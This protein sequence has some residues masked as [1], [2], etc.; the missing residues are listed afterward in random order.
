MKKFTQRWASFHAAESRAFTLIELLVVIT[1]IAI[2]AAM[3]LPALA[4]AKC[5]ATK[6][7]CIS[8]KHQIQLA[9]AMYSHDF[10]DWLVPNSPAGFAG[11][12][13]GGNSDVDWDVAPANIIPDYYKTNVLG[14]YVQN[15]KVYACP[16]DT[17]ESS[18]GRRLRSISMNGALC[19]DLSAQPNMYT[20]IQTYCGGIYRIYKKIGDLTSPRPVNLWV[21]IDET[22]WSLEDGYCQLKLTSPGYPN[23]PAYYDC[24]GACLSFADGHGEWH[25]WHW[26]GTQPATPTSLGA[27]IL[28]VPYKKGIGHMTQTWGSAGI[29]NDWQWLTDRASAIQGTTGPL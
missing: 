22:M 17:I 16:N 24:G 8:N 6:T 11:G 14:P 5:K 18:N 1:I 13:C 12:W 28:T 9:T 27:G 26:A 20:T 29:D 4:R 25:K 3:L 21:F 10:N 19:G 2:L 7:S 23:P 15:V